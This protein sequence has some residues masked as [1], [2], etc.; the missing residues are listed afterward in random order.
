[1]TE[2]FCELKSYMIFPA[3]AKGK[4]PPP[5]PG[6]VSHSLSLNPE[7][8]VFFLRLGPSRRP[9]TRTHGGGVADPESSVV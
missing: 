6:L 4:R 2:S 5:G 3:A 7:P 9:L 8:Q 1:M